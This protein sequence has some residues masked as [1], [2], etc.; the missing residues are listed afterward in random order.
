MKRLPDKLNK[1]MGI[2]SFGFRGKFE[3]GISNKVPF[4]ERPTKKAFRLFES[5]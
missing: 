1:N 5:F 4:V 2:S 3:S